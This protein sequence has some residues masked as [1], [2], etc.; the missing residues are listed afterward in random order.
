[1]ADV[2]S[3]DKD[4]F[5]REQIVSVTDKN[6]FVEAGAGSGKTTMLVNRMV[7]MVEQGKE[8]NKICAITFTKAAASEFY[9]R[10]QEMLIKRSS[11]GHEWN[12]TGEAGMLPA[13]TEQTRKRCEE[14]LKEIDLCFMGTIDSFC[15]MVLSEH[16]SEAGIPSDAHIVTDAEA[17]AL[18]RQ[19]YVKICRGE[20]G[21]DLAKKAK[22]F[23]QLFRNA[24]EV[25][26]QGCLFFMNNRNV[27]FNNEQRQFADI[28]DLQSKEGDA[29]TR[30][31]RC[32]AEHKT[33]L[34]GKNEIWESIEG[35]YE[36]VCR[37]WSDDFRGVLSLF[38]SLVSDNSS[39]LKVFPNAD[40]Y[41]CKTELESLFELGDETGYL[42]VKQDNELL[43][44][45]EAGLNADPLPD[46]DSSL[47]AE[48]D[49]L[50][51]AIGV[52]RD[53]QQDIQCGGSSS[54]T[55]WKKIDT[56]YDTVSDCW[57]KKSK[58]VLKVLKKI[59]NLRV[60][61]KAMVTYGTELEPVFSLNKNARVELKPG[62]GLTG[63]RDQLKNIQH[64]VAVQFMID[65]CEHLEQA[66]REKGALTFFDYLY[67]L[68][69]M[70]RR[71]AEGN[72]KLIQHIYER[73]SYF[74]IDEFQDTNPLQAEVFFYLTAEK[75][76]PRWS[77][78][79]PKPGSLFIVGDPK[80]SIYRFRGADVTSFLNV[81]K[82]FEKTGGTVLSLTKN[83][84]SVK[85][86][87][88]YY[89][90]VFSSLLPD[91]TENQS[92]FE[93]I[94][95]PDDRGNE[96]QG[97]FTYKAYEAQKGYALG[98]KHSEKTDPKQIFKIIERLVNNDAYK[99]TT[100]EDP[101]PRNIRYSDIMV[102]TY[103]KK[104]LSPIMDQLH[105]ENIPMK[106]EGRVPFAD[107]QALAAIHQIFAAVSDKN[108]R[109][110]LY[111][112]LTGTLSGL[113]EKELLVYKENKGNVDLGCNLDDCEN[114]PDETFRLVAS[115]IVKLKELHKKS[116]GM[117]PAA[118]FSEILERFKVYETVDTDNMEVLYYTLELIRNAEQSGKIV[119]LQDADGFMSDL[120]AGRAEE[121][122]C[123]SLTNK[124]DCV[125]LANLHK[126][127]GL[128]A[129]VVIMAAAAE[130]KFDAASRIR[131]HVDTDAEGYLFRLESERNEN[132]FIITYSESSD[133][134]GKKGDEENDLAAE[135]IRLMYVGATRAR[136][137]LI[138]SNRCV[139][140]SNGTEKPNSKWKPLVDNTLPDFF[141]VNTNPP[142]GINTSRD[143]VD[144]SVLYEEAE[145]SCALNNRER[146]EASYKIANPSK[147]LVKSKLAD[148]P[149][150]TVPSEPMDIE[151]ADAKTT[152]RMA[153]K[154]VS[155]ALLG[156][157]VHKLM[158]ILV[159]TRNKMKTDEMAAE[160]IR[161]FTG[162]LTDNKEELKALLKRVA[163]TMQNGGYVQRNGMPQDMLR[164]LLHA[165]EVY[166][167]V[168]F[169]YK[170]VTEDGKDLLWDGTMDVVYLAGGKWH[171]VDY[172]T[173]ADGNALDVKYQ[174]QLEAYKKAFREITGQEADAGTYH[175]DI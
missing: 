64:S 26:A 95:L 121:E 17:K 43:E 6:F 72:G 122:R 44:R 55:A 128:E 29:V 124:R 155:P 139:V 78:C 171:I 24:E 120:L 68:R 166:C 4:T 54:G 35:I 42:E 105:V 79:V 98:E 37:N 84:R 1:M 172:K 74:L 39:K 157:M 40:F 38:K 160:V 167:E 90:K 116:Q 9:N 60:I 88:E 133:F 45:I 93:E 134:P 73:H 107:N 123:L 70:L 41:R 66:M 56:I 140:F 16:P 52:L 11:P 103:G 170:E 168:P 147:Q 152:S 83:F 61:P 141:V 149:E 65:C 132:G 31:V 81:K 117:S 23:G 33:M 111:G 162:P 94:P 19:Q 67:Y 135:E 115:Q 71:D 36:M 46:I 10:F 7:A 34:S 12:D 125:H 96:F 5:A 164:T 158:E 87:C 175:I 50:I 169:S 32:L 49:V 143:H 131:H 106:V 30:A 14:A 101:E 76:V 118:L 142:N 174:E 173:N 47:A 58:D 154:N 27:H 112:A 137:A 108:N 48:R 21:T 59:R 77:Q 144:A 151:A 20:Y 63:I 129:P 146:E 163:E 57:G 2:T 136:N 69:E 92:K 86:L 91:E 119:T 153:I 3:V 145:K 102:I 97:V 148:E 100:K 80:Q 138:I 110:G 159:T 127:K 85:P 15:S 25:F 18:F 113:S 22:E 165:E 82:L 89:N 109:A 150:N 28:D 51:R 62:D 104:S 53:H 75:P 130:P 99:I 156:T 13:P 126:V 161:E 8:I 114:N